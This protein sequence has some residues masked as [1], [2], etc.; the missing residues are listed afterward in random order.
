M[1]FASVGSTLAHDTVLGAQLGLFNS[2]SYSCSARPVDVYP[3]TSS[4][5]VTGDKT[6]PGPSIGPVIGSKSF[7]TGWVPVGVH[8]CRRARRRGRA[9]PWT[10]RARRWSNGWTQGTTPDDGLAVGAS[11]TDSYGWKKFTFG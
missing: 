6:Y 1:N 8:A 4:W 2:W 5:S 9:S 10:T 7:A 11:S 3:V